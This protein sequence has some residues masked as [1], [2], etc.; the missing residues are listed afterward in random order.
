MYHKVYILKKVLGMLKLFKRFVGNS[1]LKRFFFYI[2]L[3]FGGQQ[4]L[5]KDKSDI[6]ADLSFKNRSSVYHALAIPITDYS[7][8]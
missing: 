4:L 5:K 1:R 3:F 8:L 6:T 7:P 2:W